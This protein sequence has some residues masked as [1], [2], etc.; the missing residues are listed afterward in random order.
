MAYPT[1]E[2]VATTRV[3]DVLFSD[4]IFLASGEQHDVMI[5]TDLTTTDRYVSPGDASPPDD[6]SLFES[7]MG[8]L[9]DVLF[10]TT[11][12]GG[13]IKLYQGLDIAGSSAWFLVDQW[14]VSAG[15]V[16]KQSAYRIDASYAKVS[17][18]NTS[19]GMLIGSLLVRMSSL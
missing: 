1:R 19:G 3:C 14:L 7:S 10:Y 15:V 9:L 12:P 6:L 11:I 18:I 5:E 2:A 4:I 13:E 8:H 17:V 16:F